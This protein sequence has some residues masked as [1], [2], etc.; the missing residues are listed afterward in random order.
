MSAMKPDP[1]IASASE[2]NAD[3]PR[4]LDWREGVTILM[5]RF[6]L[7]VFV[8][9]V[10]FLAAFLHAQRQTPY[11][12]SRATLLVEAQIPK[13]L[14]YQDLM[15]YNIRN[16]EYFNTH[17]NAL[18][19]RNM[20]TQALQRSGLADRENFLPGHSLAAKVDMVRGWVTI[21]AIEKSR[22]INVVVEHS[23]AQIASDLANALAEAYIQQ[24]LENRMGASMQ[25]IDWL[26]E[27]SEEYRAKLEKGFHE[28][29][30]YR[31][32]TGSVSLEDD[33]NI[34]IEKLKALNSALT[35][36]QTER[37]RAETNWKNVQQQLQNGGSVV[38]VVS[39]LAG[40]EVQQARQRLQE[41]QRVVA[42]LRQR[43]R[44]QHPDLQQALESEFKLTAQLERACSNTVNAL[45]RQYEVLVEHEVH[46][47]QALA[48]QEQEAF[49]LDRKLV[50]YNELKR[51]IETDQEIHRAVLARMKEAS[52]AE[53]LPSDIIRLAEEARPAKMPFR[54]RMGQAMARG[55]LLGGI[56]GLGA[57]FLF[58]YADHR[59]RRSEEIE[60]MLNLPVLATVPLILDKTDR[61]RSQVFKLKS[62]GEVAEAFRTLRASLLLKGDILETPVLMVTSTG[63]SE[64]K[65]LISA[66]LAISL[67]RDGRRTLLIDGD[68]RRT[69]LD[70]TFG[71]PSHTPGLTEALKG[72][73]YWRDTVR[74]TET[75]NLDIIPA[76]RLPSHPSELLGRQVLADILT[77][78]KGIYNHIIL[79]SPPILGISDTLV[80]LPDVDAV[81]FVVRYGVTHSLGAGHAVARLREGG[82]PCLGVILNGVNLSSFANSYYYR[83]YGAYG[84]QTY[85]PDPASAAA[86]TET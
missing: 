12:R 18:H 57:I 65:S 85:Q 28:L 3:A 16:L 42:N 2:T 68:L 26:H 72:H 82:T 79:D 40:E 21:N 83:R 33:Q 13:I 80:L 63:S 4:R 6:W 81:L 64:G 30:E 58:Y 70:K 71:I 34:V 14:N 19:S 50:R 8:A 27:R 61:E 17:L 22:M 7:G 66:N 20:L 1:Y 32:Q 36:A 5:E 39:L 15:A 78:A 43:Y 41:Q 29:Q 67:A 60:R 84:Y 46:L 75:P 35:A 69:S 11:Y 86:F 52:M 62:T 24:D 51:N 37:I 59:F 9:A 53:S 48:E 31:E 76:G 25:A 38:E 73:L 74:A 49:E 54:P 44:E 77:E 56:L 45:E 23:D 10:V 47:Q 55:A